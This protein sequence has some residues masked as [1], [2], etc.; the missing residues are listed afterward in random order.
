MPRGPPATVLGAF[1]TRFPKNRGQRRPECLGGPAGAAPRQRLV[2]RVAR[3]SR[4]TSHM[5]NLADVAHARS[6]VG[7]RNRCWRAALGDDRVG[8]AVLRELAG[9]GVRGCGRS[10]THAGVEP[11]NNH[12]ERLLRRAVLWR[13][14]S[15]RSNSAAGCCFVERIWPSSR[16]RACIGRTRWSISVTLSAATI[17]EVLAAR[18]CCPDGERLPFLVALHFLFSGRQDIEVEPGREVVLGGPHTAG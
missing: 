9:V 4:R 5:T 7:W 18:L 17:A 14:R 3:V 15:F 6:S 1:E 8:G 10:A 11:T 12:M 16:R 13:R 2:R